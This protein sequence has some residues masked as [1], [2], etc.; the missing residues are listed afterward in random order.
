M[1]AAWRQTRRPQTA[2]LSLRGRRRVGHPGRQRDEAGAKEIRTPV[3]PRQAFDIVVVGGGSAGC[4]VARRL[5]ES[6]DR[7]VL[8][9]EAGPDLRGATPADCRDGWR[10]PAIPDWGYQSEPDAAGAT[11]GLRRGRLLGGTSWLTRF[12]VRGA[13]ADFDAWAA[14]G[15]PGWRFE[16]VLPAFRRLEA[17]AEFGAD[18]WHGDDGPIPV[19]RYPGLE[20]S[21]IHAA[22]LQALDAL[23]VPSVDDHNRPAAIGVGRMPMSSRDGTRVTSVDAYLPPDW[24]R[25]NLSI[26]GDSAVA[27]VV[28]DAGRAAGVDLVDGTTISAGSIVLASGTYGSPMILMRSGIGPAEHLR[29]LGIDV[30]VDLPGVGSNLADHPG[31]D[32]DSGWRGAATTG[33]ILHSIATFRS[34]VAPVGGAPDLMFWVSDPEG[35]EPRFF[36]DPIL[37]KPETRGSVQLRTSDPADPPRINM[38]GLREARDVERLAEAYQRG[39]ELAG[40]PEV[41]RLSS[42]PPPTVPEG[43]EGLRRHVVENAYS[44]PHVVGTCAMGPSAETGAVVDALGRVHGVERLSVCDAS[45][46]PDPPSGFPHLVTIM[47]AEHLAEKLLAFL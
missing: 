33:P 9:L 36:L 24:R 41:R 14:R 39:L 13:A 6:G 25:R 21:E 40:R 2:R 27:R 11:S 18:P 12:A 30:R 4:V 3:G 42:E 34:S 23:G 43:A 1:T 7:S 31:V 28:L 15:N 32:L 37:L 8:L 5:A 20:P 45:I 38:P 10:L 17:D 19:T 47:L 46:I 26:K 44:I 35:D 22:A 16:D 29:G